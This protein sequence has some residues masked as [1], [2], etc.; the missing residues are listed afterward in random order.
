[1]PSPRPQRIRRPTKRY[2]PS[3]NRKI[4]GPKSTNVAVR[5]FQ[6]VFSR[7]IFESIVNFCFP[8]DRPTTWRFEHSWNVCYSWEVCDWSS[9]Y[10]WRRFQR[11][12]LIVQEWWW[13]KFWNPRYRWAKIGDHRHPSARAG[14]ELYYHPER[15]HSRP[16][17][18]LWWF[19]FSIRNS[20]TQ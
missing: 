17:T 1:M 19:G 16:A 14:T 20:A 5:S 15:D 8:L 2:S 6:N 10:L 13:E 3:E 12:N 4:E 18:S 7:N 9:W 11:F